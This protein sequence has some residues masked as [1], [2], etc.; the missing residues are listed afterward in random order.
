[1]ADSSSAS[2]DMIC[3]DILRGG[4]VLIGVIVVVGTDI[5]L[6]SCGIPHVLLTGQCK[7]H[8]SHSRAMIDNWLTILQESEQLL[9]LVRDHLR[10]ISHSN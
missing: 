7:V 9:N 6:E 2:G 8:T 5:W 3:C 10:N 4:V 1:M